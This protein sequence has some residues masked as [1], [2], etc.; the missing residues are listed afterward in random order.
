MPSNR[1]R[2]ARSQRLRITAEAV[3][4]YRAGDSLALARALELPPWHSS[5]IGAEGPCP[6]P[7]ST[8]A[9]ETWPQA[10]ELRQALD[11]AN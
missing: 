6:Y 1:R 9:F 8:S 3:D 10:V 5:P 4:A 7:A 11:R 2:R